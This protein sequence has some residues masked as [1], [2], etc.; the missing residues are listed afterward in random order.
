M[1]SVTPPLN[2]ASPVPG[3]P[4][5]SITPGMLTA[6]PVP[7]TPPAAYAGGTTYALN[8]TVSEANPGTDNAL[9]VYRSLQASNTGHTPSSSPTWWVK[10][11]TTYPEWAAGTYAAGDRVIDAAT[12]YEWLSLVGSNTAKPGTDETKWQLQGATNRFRLFDLLRNDVTTMPSGSVIE[13]TPGRR[14]DA[15]GAI[16]VTALSV[17]IEVVVSSVVVW[18]ATEVLSTRVVSNWFE[19]FYGEFSYKRKFG[20][21]DL[22]QYTTATIRLTFTGVGGADVKVS[23]LVVGKQTYIGKM[24]YDAESDALNF[25][26]N[27]RSETGAAILI[28]KRSIPKVKADIRIPAGNVTT[29][30]RLR[31][32]DLNAIPALWGGVT[33]EANP[34]FEPLLTIGIY[35]QFPITMDRA[36]EALGRVEIEGT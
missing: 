4:F 11:G 25:S 30:Q 16:G 5:F 2:S 22:P 32:E 24:Q 6:S 12:H 36:E 28:P 1:A 33:D 34:Y 31:D 7:E 26:K 19:Y 21:F 29:I 20:R 13:I 35:K 3:L 27:D 14:V 17:L 8:A 18:S 9:D 15:V 10:V 23:R